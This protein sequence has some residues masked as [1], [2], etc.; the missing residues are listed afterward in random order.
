[1]KTLQDFRIFMETARHG[2]LSEVARQMDMTPAATSAAVKRLEAEI[3]APLFVR[4]TRHLRLTQD[5]EAFLKHCEQA[6]ALIED[7]AEAIRSGAS[8]IR[9]TLMLSAPSD[10]GRNALLGWMDEFMAIHPEI[11]I[12]LQLSDR[13]ANIYNQPVDLALRYG[14]PPD[15]SL[16]ALPIYSENCRVLCAS[17]AYLEQ[18]GTPDS[19]EDLKH[20][21][22]LRFMVGETIQSQWPFWKDDVYV[23][24]GVKGNRT[25]DDGEAVTRWALAGH[26]IAYKSKLD[27]KAQLDSKELVHVC[28]EWKG[29]HAPL[30]LICADR[31]LL[32][33]AVKAL[34]VFLTEKCQ[35]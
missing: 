22:C 17:P 32:S 33:P 4:S 24:V 20:H 2:S 12:R 31:R 18:H 27:I 8:V 16:I 15:S 35:Q 10:L 5:G 34:Q 7:S 11:E 6:V 9:G 13:I 1:M 19:P 28:P 3:G 25:S 21:Q 29:Q 30:N 14:E 23:S 26:G